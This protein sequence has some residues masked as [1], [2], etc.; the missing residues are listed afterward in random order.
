MRNAAVKRGR[1]S[2][3]GLTFQGT[4]GEIAT[5]E[6]AEENLEFN[7]GSSH[8][9]A[10]PR[11]TISIERFFRGEGGRNILLP[12]LLPTLECNSSE[13][14]AKADGAELSAGRSNAR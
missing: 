12:L 5:E 6:V 14:V 3:R 7:A 2:G 4:T 10:A 1:I 13:T 8:H 11:R 9:A